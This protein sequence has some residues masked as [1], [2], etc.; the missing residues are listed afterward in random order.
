MN[1]DVVRGLHILAVIAWMAGL[2]MLPR[3]YAYQSVSQPGG[4]LEQKMMVAARSLRLIILTPAMLIAWAL[5]LHL[6]TTYLIGVWSGGVGA[7]FERTPI[8]FWIKL[9]LVLALSGYHGFLVAEGRRLAKGE[10]RR[11]ERFWRMTGEIP[12]VIAIIVVMMA[13]L[14]PQ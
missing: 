12:F 8:W 4:E 14:E 3:L 7:L 1:Y 13:T 2:L 10:R 9:I 6:Y 11:S 5:G